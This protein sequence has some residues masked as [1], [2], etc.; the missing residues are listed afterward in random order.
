M[1]LARERT[2]ARATATDWCH[3][4]VI[5]R[6]Q[7]HTRQTHC[8]S[9][10]TLSTRIPNSII[11][12]TSIVRIQLDNLRSVDPKASQYHSIP[13]PRAKNH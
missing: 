5:M 3:R 12:P 13:L 1:S 8:T 10:V 2:S 6:L 4:V 7:N 11:V 9:N